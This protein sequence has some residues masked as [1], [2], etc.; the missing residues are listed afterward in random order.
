MS[1]KEDSY[2]DTI[3]DLEEKLKKNVALILKL[4]NS[5]QEMFRLGPKLLSVYDQQLKH[6]LGI[7]LNIRENKDTLDDASK[8]QQKVKEKIN[9]PFV[10]ENKQNYWTVDFQQINAFYKDFVP[11]KELFAEQKYFPSSLIPS[12]KNSNAT[13]LIPAS[14]PSES[15]LIIELD[16]MRSCF[17]KLSELIQKNCKRASIFYTS[18]EEIQ[19]ND[20]C[21]DQIKPIVNELQFYFELFRTR[22]Q[23]DIKEMKDVF[24]LTESELYNSL[25]AEIKHMKRKSIK[26]QEE[27]QAKIKILEKD[28]QR[29]EKQSVDFELKLLLEK[30]K[31]KWDSTLKNNNTKSL[32]Y[33]WISKIEKLEHENVSLDFKVQSLIKNTTILKNVEKRKSINTKFDTTNGFQTPLCITL[34]N[35]HAFQKKMDVSKTKKNHVVLKPIT[36]QTSPDKQTGINLNKNVI[37]PR[38]YKVV[39]PQ[40][41]QNAKSSLSS[42]GMNAASSVR[43]SMNRDSH[44]KNSVLANS[45]NILANV[46]SNMENVIHDDVANASKAKNPLCVSCM[47]NLL[48]SCH[49]KCLAHHRLNA[50]RTLTTKSRTPKSSDTTYVVLKTRFSEKSAQSKNVD[51]TSVVSKS[52]I[53]VGGSSKLKISGCS[54]HMT[55][56]RSQLRDFIEK[57]M[58]TVRFRNDNFAA[59]TGYGDYIQG[60]INICHVL[61]VEGHGHNLFSIGQFCDGD[62]EVAFRSK[63]CYVRNLEGDDFLTGG[64]E[65]NLYTISISDMA[66]SL[67]VCLMSKVTS[68]KSWL[69]HRRLLHLNFDTINDLSRLDLVD[70]PM[71]TPSK[72][73]LDNLFS[74]MFEEYF[75]KKSFDTPT[76]SVAQPTQL[77]EDLPSTSSIK[78]DELHQE[79]SANFEAIHRLF[80]ITLQVMK[81]EEGIDFEELFAPVARLEA[82]SKSAIAI[83]CN[84]VQHSKTK[85]IDIRYH[86]I[87]EHI[88]KGTVELYIVGTKYQL[89]DLF[90][91]VLPKERFEYLVHR[92]VIIM[93]HQQLVADVHLDELCLPN[94][95]YDLMDANKKIDLEHV[96]CPPESKMLTNIIKN[97]L[98]KFMI[99]RKVLSL[100]LDDF[101]TIF[102]LPQAT[103]NN[104]DSF[105]RPP[106][107]SDMIPFYKNH[108]GF[109]IEVK[110]PSS[111]KTTEVFRIDVP[112]IQSPLTESTQGTHKTLNAPR[113]LTHKVDATP[114]LTV[115]K[116][117][118]LI[119]QDTLQVSLAKHKSRQ[120][121]E[122]KE[123]V[124][125]VE[126]HL[127]FEEIE[128]MVDRH[129]HVVD[130]SSTPMNDEHNIP[131][132]RLEPRSDKE[133]PEVGITDVIVPVNVYDEEE[134]DD[135]ITNKVYEL[136]QKEKGKNV[137]ESRIIPFPTPI[138]SPR[139]HT[140]LEEGTSTSANQ[141]QADDYD[142]WTDSY[143]SDDDEIPTKQVSQDIIEEVSLNVNEA[144]LKKIVDEMLRQRCTSGDEH[145]YHIDQM[146]NFL[147]SDIVWVNITTPTMSFPGI[148]E[149]EMFSIIY[150]P[151][152]G[153]IY[154]NSKKEKRV[155]RH[156]EIR[157]FCDTTLNRVL[158]GLNSY[159]NDVKYGY[160]QRDITKDEMKEVRKKSLRD[161]HEKHP[162]GSGTVA[163]KPPKG[164]KI[165]PTV[166][167]SW[168]N[169]EDDNNDAIDSKNEGNDEENKS[170][171]DRTPS[172]SEKVQ[173]LSKT[174]M[175]VNQIPNMINKKDANQE[176]KNDDKSEGDEDKGMDDTT[177]QFSDDVHDKEADVEMTDAQQEKENLE[178]TQEK[179]VE[180]AHVTILT[181]AKETKVLDANFSHSSDLASK[182]IKNL[183]IH[184]NDAEIVSPLDVHVHREVPRIHTS[185]L[186][187]VPASVIPEGSPVNLAKAS[188]Q[189]Q[190]TYEAA[191]TLTEFELQ[192]IL[193][194]E[195][196]K[197]K[198]KIQ[199]KDKD[200]SAGSDQ[201]IKKRKTS[202][203]TEPTTGLKTKDSISGSSKGITSQPKSSGKNV[204]SKVPEFKV[205]DTDMPHDQGGNLGTTSQPKSSGKNVQSE[206]P[207]FEV[208]DIDMPQDRGGNLGPAFRLLKGTRS[209]YA[210]L[211]YK[212][213]ECYKALLEKLDWE[214][215]EGEDYPFDLTKPLPL[216]K[217][218]LTSLS[219]D[220]VADFAIALKMFTRSLVIQKRV[221]DLQ[222]GFESYQKKIN[223]TKLDTVRLISKKGTHTLHI[224][225]LKDSFMSTAS[226]EI[227][228]FDASAGNHVK[229][230]L[231]KLNLPNHSE[232]VVTFALEGFPDKYNNVCGII[233]HWDNFS[234]LKMTR[235]MLTT[236]EMQLKSKSLSLPVDL[237]SSSPM[238]LM[239]ETDTN[240]RP[241]NPQVKSWRPCYNFARGSCH[242]GNEYKFVHDVN[243]K[244]SRNNNV[245]GNNTDELFSKLL[246]QLGFKTN[247]APTNTFCSTWEY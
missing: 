160:N 193:I 64:R 118:E 41:T 166:I 53:D 59:I 247:L 188:S 95:R 218:R 8:S 126:K 39:T 35:K 40:E 228:K 137:E 151:V 181:V 44:D 208:A 91:K 171:D 176:S 244:P 36:L 174:R 106:S 161:F 2:H 135:K 30:E 60:D 133:S 66:A 147:K 16:K 11:Q 158:E 7:P 240:R 120:E 210:E 232:D 83:S 207:E 243:V 224:K 246:G 47:Q 226:R 94:K 231:L 18:L 27:L 239:A 6:G 115:D 184:H 78:A 169:D 144:K 68:T 233:H 74:P 175:E 214:N 180:D 25:H 34:I 63:T 76:N 98:L 69:W 87:K 165:T 102:H 182:F 225:T 121:Q 138:R 26:I 86:F 122:T 105:V 235:L 209:N 162:S 92:I 12:D 142:F 84:P 79:D 150:D 145:Q 185:T 85:H 57:F 82:D 153:I 170:D 141:E 131:G 54:K 213:E 140:D 17:Q 67:P 56:D 107:F 15:P 222:L 190:S 14:M 206:I 221:R 177:N 75:G 112:P 9:D 19:L 143:A 104:H 149:F 192:K 216:V 136:K 212:F 90:T 196:N 195:M 51:T 229:E 33:S 211:E 245:T 65:S 186:L 198:P 49:D 152:H 13:A 219:G 61:Y 194:D 155:I 223:V 183:D 73:D 77:H 164:D 123:N 29:C 128:K 62:L 71:N 156:S 230:I 203:D 108:L 215:P 109:T 157:K 58:D 191:A 129:E 220:D 241:S 111:F 45:K 89:A 205:A 236:E 197:T 237:S 37:A 159:N 72:E 134:E 52:K 200:P 48:I 178:I 113:S 132:T 172:D 199:G 22:F 173:I 148:K 217:N 238:V 1:E 96:Q 168:G 114:V 50:S 154:K 55:G 130:D 167:K 125:L 124:A 20:F 5:L 81:Q 32:D 187:T 201:E 23:R 21:Q 46:I 31:H 202:K 28:V 42:I 242:I 3:I 80:H 10:F 93:A 116:A 97:H 100:T 189:P 179:V 38:I 101:R 99:D 4:G 110:T 227:G 88:E 119:L 103:D 234:D 117:K 24:V 139:I 70:E 43:R 146:K 163:K 127:A 204:Q